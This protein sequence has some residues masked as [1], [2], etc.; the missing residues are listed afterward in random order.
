MIEEAEELPSDRLL[1]WQV[2]TQLLFEKIEWGLDVQ[3]AVDTADSADPAVE[4]V[5]VYTEKLANLQEQEY[6]L[7]LRDNSMAIKSC[8]DQSHG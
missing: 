7:D 5:N 3:N 8:L 1:V 6:P 4:F 2:R